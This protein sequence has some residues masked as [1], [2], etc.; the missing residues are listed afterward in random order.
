MTVYTFLGITIFK[1]KIYVFLTLRCNLQIQEKSS[2]LRMMLPQ[3]HHHFV[4]VSTLA[5]IIQLKKIIILKGVSQADSAIWSYT[6][7]SVQ[8]ILLGNWNTMVSYGCFSFLFR[9][10]Q[11]INS[12]KYRGFLKNEPG[13]CKHS[14]L[15]SNSSSSIYW[16]EKL[17]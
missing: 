5:Y 16:L 10:Q 6:R 1:V 11:I 15:E 14:G 17:Q 9:L 2:F 12:T 8:M 7:I 4:L 13:F 3:H